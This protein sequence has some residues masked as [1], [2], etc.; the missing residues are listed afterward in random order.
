MRPRLLFSQRVVLII[1][2]AFALYVVGIWLTN[3]GTHLF[4]GWTGYAPL[5]NNNT[6]P[7]AG[8]LHAW[9]RLVIWLLLTLVWTITSLSLLR[10]TPAAR[11]ESSNTTP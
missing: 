7:Y 5:Q 8:G 11:D 6:I 10:T 1:A 9:V 3:L 4:A 2:L